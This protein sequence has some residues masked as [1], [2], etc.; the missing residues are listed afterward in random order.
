MTPLR[1]LALGLLLTAACPLPAQQQDK[2]KA[3]SAP[4]KPQPPTRPFDGPG[5]PKFVRLDDKP[6]AVPPVDA[7]GDYL[8][9]P[10]YVPAEATKENP[11]A[12]KGRVTQFVMDSKDCR[13]FNPGIARDEFGVPDPKNPKTLIVQTRNVDYRRAITVYVPA[14]HRA[15]DV[16]PLLVT[17]DG[18]GIGKSDQNLVRILDN[19]IHAGRIPPLVCVMIANGGG[20]AQGHERGKEYDT[21]SPLFAEF[22]EE[23]VLPLVEKNAD[24]RLTPDPEMRA[25]MGVS[26]GAAAAF[27]MA[28]YRPDLWRR[29]IS[30]S[31]TFVNQQ[32]PFNP[33]T[34][35]GA[36]GYHTTLIP[37]A[38][39]KPL[40]IWMCV[41]DRDN[42]NPN[43]MRDGMHDWVEAN[44][45]M[46]KVLRDKGYRYQYL[47]CLD[48]GHGV[49]NARPQLLPQAL[50]WVWQDRAR[51]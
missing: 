43:V 40:R 7:V 14:G 8:V 48:S 23:E 31:G 38:P 12:P 22:I 10:Q 44:H 34:P 50:E 33:E 21:L 28:W 5:A 4:A 13:R 42:F 24:V 35:D 46:A 11:A 3:K 25:T 30:L 6:G 36:W 18:P 9:G 19:L 41:G 15:G 39:R 37:A 17:H 20:D 47:Y 51:R 2:K 16:S 1:L 32:W 49:G 26:S 29:V 45:R 27:T